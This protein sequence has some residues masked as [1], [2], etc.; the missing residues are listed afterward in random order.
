MSC[1]HDCKAP[2]QFPVQIHNR[3][4]LDEIDYRIGGYTEMRSRILEAIDNAPALQDWT[5]RGADDPGIALVEGAAI[6]GD[7]LTFYQR[8]YANESYLRTA[9]WRDSVSDLVRLLGYRLSPGVAGEAT[10]ALEVT[11]ERPVLV[12][13]GF[14][15]KAELEGVE[16]PVEFETSEDMTAHPHL[17]AFQLYRPREIPP[18]N[19]GESEFVVL[20]GDGSGFATD[21]RLLVGIASPDGISPKRLT[22]AEVVVVDDVEESFGE[23][24]IKI[25]GALTTIT[26]GSSVIAYKIGRSFRHF[27]HTAPP[28]GVRMR[29]DGDTSSAP[30][31]T[32]PTVFK[33]PLDEATGPDVVEP[34]LEQTEFL[35][36]QEIDDLAVGNRVLIQAALEKT[37]VVKPKNGKSGS[38]SSKELDRTLVRMITAVEQGVYAWGPTSGACTK[39][40]VNEP[41]PSQVESPHGISQVSTVDIR[42]LVFHEVIGEPVQLAAAYQPVAVASGSELYFFGAGPEHRALKDRRLLLLGPGSGTRLAQVISIDSG[43]AETD[44]RD[45]M[46]RVNL[47]QIVTYHNFEFDEAAVTVHGNLVEATQGRTEKEVILGSGDHRRSFQT[48]ALPKAPLTY[49]LDGTRTPAQTPELTVYVDRI[50][51]RQLDTLFKAGPDDHVYIVRQDA[52]G[53]SFVQFGDGLTGCRLPSGRDNVVVIYRTGIGAYGEMKPDTSVQ[54]TGKLK[55][56]GNAFL[57]RPVVGG[58]EPES[59]ANA[60]VAAPGKLQSLGRLVGLRDYESE[61]LGLPGVLKARAAWAAPDGAPMLSIVVLTEGGST[62]D[63]DKIRDTLR[64]YNRCRGAARFPIQVLHGTRQFVHL[65]IAV[66]FDAAYREADVTHSIREALGAEK[67]GSEQPEA[68]LFGIAHRQFGESVHRS[69]VVAAVQQVAG[70]VWVKLVSMRLLPDQEDGTGDPEALPNPIPNQ[71]HSLL[72]ADA[73]HVLALHTAHLVISLSRQSDRG[74]C[75]T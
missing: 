5:H 59:E 43:A 1:K 52:D 12:P 38:Q 48:F 13:A 56:F 60:R 41:L 11:G 15:L 29:A 53:E 65:K 62:A 66:G 10:F 50:E 9:R 36:D 64:T 55:E 28:V 31:V 6:V 75:S 69:H 49:L 18:I 71:V 37:T 58:A 23:Y 34:A 57:H 3:P 26:S 72:R 73:T 16:E 40:V 4:G 17:S 51:W 63:T 30:V 67:R 70:V 32:S 33:R 19:P 22:N 44:E 68:G 39:V 20:T 54:A 74:D 14:G 42:S 8:L 27:G 24:R 47:D 46:R 35:L 2:A 7:I 21:D 61:A 45:R 25:K